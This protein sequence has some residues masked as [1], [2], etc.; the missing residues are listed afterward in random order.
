MPPNTSI[1]LVDDV[2]ENLQ[3]L[4][5]M[6]QSEG[7]QIRSARN[8]RRAL[9]SATLAPPDLI[10]LDIK[11][12]EVDG[13]QAC[14]LFKSDARLKDI[15]VIIVSALNDTIDKVK[16]FEAGG[17]DYITKPFKSLEV[18]ARVRAHLEIRRQ[19]RE[20]AASYQ[21]LQELEE[22]RDSLTHM[23]VHDMRDPLMVMDGY[24]QMVEMYEAATLSVK[25]KYY[26]DQARSGL[27]RL[28]GMAADML[29]VSKTEAGRLELQPGPV[30]LATLLREAAA[31]GRPQ[32]DAVK[33]Q[34]DECPATMTVMLDEELIRRVLQNLVENAV[35][36]SPA[37]GVV[38]LALR[39]G[40]GNVR[41]S[42]QDSG[43]GVAPEF[44]ERIFEKFGQVKSSNRRR[45]TGLGLAFCK[46]V[47][48]AHG[49]SIGVESLPGQGST[50][51]FTLP[52]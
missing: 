16:A 46:L 34:V 38:H 18:R 51:W 13:I 20:L 32:T 26:M 2:P 19:Q 28:V 22:L 42:V 35:K 40:T 15:P 49:G 39:S 3:L 9:E 1:L 37:I 25:G 33:I 5:A 17:V 41:V 44:Q 30:D 24:L 7:Y 52:A 23:V 14:A 50:F 31:V 4:T 45:G 43:P 36:F 27:Q 21:R 11:M 12:P 10:L 8:S 48:A 29:L 6:L 47:V